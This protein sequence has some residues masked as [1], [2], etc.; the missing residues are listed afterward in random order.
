MTSTHRPGR[1][2]SDAVGVALLAA[3]PVMIAEGIRG[4]IRI[5]GELAAQEITF[6]EGRAMPGHLARYAGRRVESG[7]DAMAYADLIKSHVEGATG[8]R[9]YAQI[10]EEVAAARNNGEDVEKLT[11]MRQTAF[12]GET[13]RAGLMSAYQAWRLTTLVT[14]LGALF[15][16]LGATLLSGE[17][18]AMSE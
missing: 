9:T 18:G 16:A 5:R 6:P 4:R 8:G 7:S 17:R 2:L 13:L 12:M 1:F 10:S 3:G 11:D 14:G 15:G